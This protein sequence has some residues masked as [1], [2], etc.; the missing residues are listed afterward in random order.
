M[1]LAD[2]SSPS[3]VHR[4]PP[5][6]VASPTA[7]GTGGREDR[8]RSRIGLNAAG[9]LMAFVAAVGLL[10]GCA[11][12][13]AP[14]LTPAQEV[15]AQA[16]RKMLADHAAA[17]NAKDVGRAAAD[18]ADQ[19]RIESRV[20][21]GTVNRAQWQQSIQ[22]SVTAGQFPHIEFGVSRVSFSDPTHATVV[23]NF[24]ATQAGG[25]RTQDGL[26]WKMEKRD[27]RWLI[28]ESRYR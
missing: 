24:V 3:R 5:A 2:L 12:T 8:M 19:A 28:V 21:G 14:P 26:E 17:L 11:A 10:S 20:A 15:E 9:L 25:R 18:Y 27:G 7:D 13:P 6:G 23:G 1:T 22:Q 4:A 16:I